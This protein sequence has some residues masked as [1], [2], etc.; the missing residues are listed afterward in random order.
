MPLFS[1]SPTPQS[2]HYEF[3]RLGSMRLK[4][5][6]KMLAILPEIYKSGIWKKYAGTIEGYAG[7][8]GDIADTTARKRLRLEE[9]LSNKPFLRAAIQTVGV[10]KVAMVAKITTP[11]MDQSMAEK[12]CNMSKMAVQ[13]LS[14]EMRAR[15][16]RGGQIGEESERQLSIGFNADMEKSQQPIPVVS[17]KFVLDNHFYADQSAHCKAVPLTKKIELDENSTFL[18][19]KL[20]KKLCKNLSDKEFLKLIIEERE[21]Q[22]FPMHNSRQAQKECKITD[23][24]VLQKSACGDSHGKDVAVKPFLGNTSSLATSPPQENAKPFIPQTVNVLTQIAIFRMKYSTTPTATAREKV[25]IPSSHF[26]KS[27]MSLHTII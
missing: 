8:F 10:H 12:L 7:K 20:K 15:A 11:E 26:A 6:N 14:K 23:K 2:L 9:N 27:T 21:K 19:L 1:I 17:Q 22:E 18:F 25:T 5:K 24:V 4:L 3:V 16:T 13:S